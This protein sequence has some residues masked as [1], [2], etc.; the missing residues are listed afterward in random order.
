MLTEAEPKWRVI[1]DSVATI[2]VI[3][4]AWTFLS[5]QR[6]IGGSGQ[7]GPR[8]GA[9]PS[10]PRDRGVDAR[11]P[12]APVSLSGAAMLGSP[13]APVAILIYSDFQ[14]PYCGR[15]A[16]DTMPQIEKTF[17]EPGK[18]LIA[19]RNLPLSAIHPFARRAAQFAV[20]TSQQG[21]FWPFHNLAFQK[22]VQLDDRALNAW[23]T[24]AGADET[25]LQQC[26]AGPA[27]NLVQQEEATARL[28]RVSATPTL[29]MGILQAD[30]NLKVIKRLSGAV[31]FDRIKEELE[32]LTGPTSIDRAPGR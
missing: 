15:F 1:L 18:T 17:V 13:S 28:L 32:L 3:M 19:F 21:R 2:L 9:P 5:S 22:Q 8:A 14:C 31:P 20:C 12:T 26:L 16:R 25:L 29:F 24:A 6:P 27:G 7:P 10:G 23:S 4:V 11:V 30:K